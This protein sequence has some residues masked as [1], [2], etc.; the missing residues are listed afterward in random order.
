MKTLLKLLAD[1]TALLL[2]LPAFGLYRLGAVALG[3]LKAFAGW[4]QAFS[5]LPGLTG[6]YLRRAFYR[7]VLPRCAAGSWIGFG[8]V[9]SHPT[10]EVGRDVYVGVYCCLGDVT[11]EDDG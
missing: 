11:L 9:F 5:L 6:V 4:A 7:L 1:G 8:T 10:A 2:V 3:P